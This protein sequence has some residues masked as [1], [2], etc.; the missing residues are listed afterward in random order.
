MDHA[1]LALPRF[2]VINKMIFRL[3]QLPITFIGM[4]MHGPRD[5]RYA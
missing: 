2:Q 3:G 4:I 1:K 5:E